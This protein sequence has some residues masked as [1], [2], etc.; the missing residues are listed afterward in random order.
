M[1]QKKYW[2]GLEELYANGDYQKHKQNEFPE[3]L[4]VLNELNYLATEKQASRRDFLK[5]LGFSL[6]AATIAAS[7]EI[8]IKKAIPYVMKPEEI[9][10]GVANYYASSFI[11]GSDYCSVLVKTREGRPIKIE[12]NKLS[13]LTKGGTSARAQ[14]SVVSLYDGQRLKFPKKAGKKSTWEV[15]DKEIAQQL[16]GASNPALLTSSIISPSTR[17][18]I[19]E[20]TQKY[21]GRHVVYEPISNAGMLA[22]NEQSMGKRAIPSYD[23][24]KA[25][26]IV[27]INCDFLGTWISPTEFA[28]D[29]I[30]NR[31]IK[32]GQPKMSKH[33]Q[34]ESYM[35][36]TGANAD[37]RF[38]IKPSQE[39]LVALALFKELGGSV[40]GNITFEDA[41]VAEAIKKAAIDL[42]SHNGK[43]LV[44]SGSNSA[45]VQMVIN[46]IN[47]KLGSYGQ[48]IDMDKTYNI[49]QGDDKA[50]EQLLADMT[51][52]K[53]GALLMHGVN[54]VYSYSDSEKVK[55]ALKK[56]KLTV[57][58]NETADE[59]SEFVNY[60][61]PTNHYLESWN[62][63]E[64]KTGFYSLVQPTIAPLFDTRAFQESLLT[65][66]GAEETN[67]YDYIRN[68]WEQN[69]ASKQSKFPSF[70]AFW[71]AALHD[72]VF[73]EENADNLGGSLLAPMYADGG[74]GMSKNKIAATPPQP[75]TPKPA[76]AVAN[77]DTITEAVVD[78]LAEPAMEL[79]ETVDTIIL[80]ENDSTIIVKNTV[81]KPVTTPAPA[82]PKP[83]SSNN[84]NGSAN[85]GTA[86]QKILATAQ[87]A[88]GMELTLF[89]NTMGDG[90]YANNPFLQEMPDPIT[91]ICW[92]NYVTVSK[93]DADEQGWGKFDV[94]E[95]K[96]GDNSVKLP[97]VIQPG[98]AKGSIGIP[99]GYGRK[100]GV[101][102]HCKVGDNAYPFVSFDGQ[103]FA[104]TK[105]EG[106][107]VKKV[108]S[109]Y[110]LAQTQMHHTIDDTHIG[111]GERTIVNETTLGELQKDP[112]A[113]N[114]YGKHFKEHAKKHHFTLFGPDVDYGVHADSHKQGHHWG[115]GIDMN[116]CIG[117]GACVVA[118][119][120][121]NNV[122]IVGQNE[123]FRAHEMHWMRIDRYYAGEGEDTNSADYFD[124]PD[125][126]FMPMMCQHCDNAPCENVCPVAATNHSSE[127]INQMAY[128]RC[129]GTRYC[130]NNCPFKVR[131]FNWY[132]YQGADSFY[133]DTIFDNDSKVMITDLTRMVLNPDVTVR[134]RGVME[135]CSFCVQRIQEVKLEAK[136]EGRPLKD[137]KM[138]TAC[139]QGCPTN[140][141][142]FGDI[143]DPNSEISKAKK[144][145]RAYSLLQ[146]IHVMSS[147]TY[148]TKVRNRE[149]KPGA[150]GHHG[151][152]KGHGDNH[153]DHGHS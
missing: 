67:F 151:H 51:A 50:F 31:K 14:A 128:N 147:I 48:T 63:A 77:T 68:Y 100:K 89:E 125:V 25:E 116:A 126:A 23:F 136:K 132:D 76:V 5:V 104:Y 153:D 85:V 49:H 102:H 29:Y 106:V 28:S 60:L 69:I 103:T 3:E 24:S 13:S 142:I 101:N 33:W 99:L 137:G 141:I 93:R 26:V 133:K 41:K 19:E 140:A 124:H 122:P 90:N 88:S 108:G 84:N 144:S 152:D 43:A 97:M 121:E 46:A 87:K 96:V 34:F 38:S 83:K 115:M 109:N 54:P 113:G 15:V 119:N 20:F 65:W 131:R 11:N 81:E 44:V 64:P 114:H 82:P 70:Q 74:A 92:D 30:E 105:T 12:G 40:S 10:P 42:K 95:V 148:L 2:K 62:D 7:C 127:G 6:G 9:L 56:V 36:L 80:A 16:S 59:T 53:V 130:A 45:D 18:L 91:K 117:C 143:N 98:Q 21:G 47:Q 94:L 57:S 118:C 120:V 4:P 1:E 73:E 35:S 139:Q 107:T 138:V 145:E 150:H 61:C 79:V 52:G 110:E 129:I 58:F 8:P 111:K 123:V 71:D 55:A 27:G 66:M 134:S 112:W 78:T 32:A 39:G 86:S 135:K 72:G 17:Q 37:K 75:L 149:A 146:E 22:A